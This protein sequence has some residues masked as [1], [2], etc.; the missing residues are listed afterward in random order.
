MTADEVSIPK[1]GL[2]NQTQNIQSENSVLIPKIGVQATPKSQ[3]VPRQQM[4]QNSKKGGGLLLKISVGFL[5][6]ILIILVVIG[7]PAYM[8]YQKG[9]VLYKNVKNLTTT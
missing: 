8:T 7:I 5:A 6:F 4:N 3:P 9:M 2:D 1:I